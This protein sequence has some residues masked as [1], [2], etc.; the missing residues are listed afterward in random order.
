MSACRASDIAYDNRCQ[1]Y[2][3]DDVSE[4]ASY[5]C[6]EGVC[7]PYEGNPLISILYICL[8]FCCCVCCCASVI[9]WIRKARLEHQIEEEEARGPAAGREPIVVRTRA[10]GPRSHP[11]IAS[12]QG[13]GPQQIGGSDDIVALQL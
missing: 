4:C 3:C 10:D 9:Y 6:E 7:Q 5:I 8:M 2:R 12:Y 11:T 1:G 13:Q